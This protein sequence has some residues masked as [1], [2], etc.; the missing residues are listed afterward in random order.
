MKVVDRQLA[1]LLCTLMHACKESA[2]DI[3][4]EATLAEARKQFNKEVR[5]QADAT[6]LPAK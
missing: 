3:S 2:Y 1:A 5:E 4:F 6:P